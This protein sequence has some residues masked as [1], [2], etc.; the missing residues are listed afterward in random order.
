MGGIE[1]LV[2]YA[3]GTALEMDRL[4]TAIGGR[5]AAFD[6][7]VVLEP[8]EQA[9]QGCAFDS[10]PLGD[11]LLGAIVRALGKMHERPPF[12]LAQAE[13]AQA[14]IEPGAPGTSGPEEDQAE[15]VNVRRR[16]AQN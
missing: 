15:L 16:H 9:R 6:P 10:H 7:A 12:S 5:A 4:A 14:L 1:N 8:I 2:E 11:F 3:S 13:W